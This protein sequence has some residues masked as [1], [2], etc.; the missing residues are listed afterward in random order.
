MVLP[1]A[2]GGSTVHVLAIDR[3]PGPVLA[4]MGAVHI[5]PVRLTL[6]KDITV[7]AS[8]A[9]NVAPG[10]TEALAGATD[11]FSA[12]RG[13]RKALLAAAGR[14]RRPVGRGSGRSSATAA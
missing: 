11:Q 1:P 9:L 6:D 5:T 12:A 4:S 10:S 14:V 8:D 13:R 3:G 7:D 2:T